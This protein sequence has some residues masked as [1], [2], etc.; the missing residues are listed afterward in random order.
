MPAKWLFLWLAGGLFY[1]LA[2]AVQ[3]E[4]FSR[5]LLFSVEREG[6][7]VSYLF[8]TMHSGDSR[9]LALSSP[10]TTALEQAQQFIMEVSLD[11]TAVLSSL[12]ELWLL[13]GQTL[14]EVAGERVYRQLQQVAEQVGIPEQTF[15]YMKPW[16]VM[17]M[18]SLPPGDYREI[19][20]TRLM[21]LALSQG[22]PILG[23]ESANEQFEVF[24]GLPIEQQVGLLELALKQYP[25]LP[26]QFENLLQAYLD[27]DLA[28]L[29]QLGTEQ[30]EDTPPALA[31]V[32]MHRLLERRNQR[33]LDRL[34]PLMESQSSFV[35][36][37]A[38]H[39]PGEQGLLTLL[40]RQGFVVSRLD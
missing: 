29:L 40:A 20:D 37:G 3:A 22:K 2:G 9:V 6:Q 26:T 36:V 13:D 17:I 12:G 28:R 35:A 15:T 18:F 4:Q 38:L 32:V 14:R 16:V 27:K 1:I 10:V 8:G 23:L 5:G 7:P 30:L 31:E 19:L 34:L 33:M 11:G 24:D 25:E 39:L 21:Q